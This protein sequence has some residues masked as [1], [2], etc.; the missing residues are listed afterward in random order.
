M[1]ANG[2]DVLDTLPPQSSTAELT[3]P[4]L[5]AAATKLGA[6]NG[7]RDET[8]TSPGSDP[9][10]V[11]L[12]DI[13]SRLTVPLLSDALDG[14][15]LT[16]QCPRLPIGPLTGFG[17]LLFGRAK[18]TLWSDMA[19]EDPEPYKL[20]LEAIDSC[21]RDDVILC[22]AAGSMR[23]GIW[24]ELLSNV[25]VARGCVGV[26]VDGAVR[27]LAKM[28]EM[29]FPVFARGP[30]PYDSRNRQRVTDYDV[31]IELDGVAV[32]PGDWIGAD[33]DGIVVVPQKIA[34]AVIQAAWHKSLE[35]NKVREAV[36]G[37]MSA[38]EAFETYGVL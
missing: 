37:G 33:R 19:H 8:A 22:A 27:D 31:A 14:L 18:T 26:I 34:A 12:A 9:L 13:R 3:S 6:I 16:M 20:E 7:H 21:H 24:G 32:A 23:S 11:P 4:G 17:G 1:I 29:R 5:I 2:T 25:A 28:T 36:R 15:G 35:E 10:P 38:T 30:N